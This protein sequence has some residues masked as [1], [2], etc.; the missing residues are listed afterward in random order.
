MVTRIFH[1]VNSRRYRAI[2][3]RREKKKEEFYA[4]QTLFYKAFYYREYWPSLNLTRADDR[5]K[6]AA[7]AAAAV[8]SLSASFL[9][10]VFLRPEIHVKGITRIFRH[11]YFT[12]TRESRERGIFFLSSSESIVSISLFRIE[13]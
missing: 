6:G 2:A 12:P 11:A 9:S 13:I 1:V 4:Q 3:R 7:A 5:K 8:S 10:R